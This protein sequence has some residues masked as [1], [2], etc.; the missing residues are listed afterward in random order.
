MEPNTAAAKIAFK[1]A[2]EKVPEKLI[3]RLKNRAV[4]LHLSLEKMTGND[5]GQKAKLHFV[6]GILAKNPCADT[7]AMIKEFGK[8]IPNPLADLVSKMLKPV[9]VDE[10]DDDYVT[11]DTKQYQQADDA[12]DSALWEIH[13][14]R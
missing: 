11:V 10:N 9:I 5:Q 7:V 6:H 3:N 8:D 13:N 1:L 4:L 12:P 2:F 14:P